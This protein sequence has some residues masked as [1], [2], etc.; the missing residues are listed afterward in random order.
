MLSGKHKINKTLGI[1]IFA[2]FE[3]EITSATPVPKDD[4]PHRPQIDGYVE[5]MSSINHSTVLPTLD[6]RSNG[7]K[8][9]LNKVI[10]A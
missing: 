10:K 7:S 4:E 8:I 1:L 2:Y 6:T 3:V 5:T 9:K